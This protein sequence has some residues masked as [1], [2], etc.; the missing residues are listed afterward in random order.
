MGGAGEPHAQVGGQLDRNDILHVFGWLDED[1][2]E[3]G[4][5]SGWNCSG[6]FLCSLLLPVNLAQFPE[7]KAASGRIEQESD[8][9]AMDD[10]FG[11][12][13]PLQLQGKERGGDHII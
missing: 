11:H 2:R 9:R 10:A 1:G 3:R 7:E 5:W 8:Q 13:G 6:L 12:G 4:G